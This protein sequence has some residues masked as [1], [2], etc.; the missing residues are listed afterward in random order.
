MCTR[1]R[2]APR[3]CAGTSPPRPPVPAAR[4]PR[5][6]W[7]SGS[8]PPGGTTTVSDM[9]RCTPAECRDVRHQPSWDPDEIPGG[10]AWERE[11][12]DGTSTWL[13][14]TRTCDPSDSPPLPSSGRRNP[15]RH[16]EVQL[17]RGGCCP[18]S[19]DVQKQAS[20]P[21]RSQAATGHVPRLPDRRPGGALLRLESAGRPAGFGPLAR[22]RHRRDPCLRKR[23]RGR[24][25]EAGA[26]ERHLSGEPAF[27]GDRDSARRLV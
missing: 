18:D 25:R 26:V 10:E 6:L 8:A 16:G 11:C 23:R 22:G 9:R 3:Q 12:D 24:A 27:R 2:R 4:P 14:D 21:D 20:P 17:G 5:A 19:S 15:V 7:C 1:V 13:W